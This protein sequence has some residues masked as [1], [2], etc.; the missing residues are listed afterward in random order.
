MYSLYGSD[1]IFRNLYILSEPFLAGKKVRR[2]SD[3]R[4]PYRDFLKF[5]YPAMPVND[6]E[7]LFI[8]DAEI[9]RK[10]AA[11]YSGSTLN[12][13]HQDDIIGDSY[14]DTE[15]NRRVYQSQEALVEL[16]QRDEV[17]AQIFDLVIHSIFITH[18]RTTS[19]GHQSHGGSA[20]GAIGAVW[21][22]MKKEVTKDDLKELFIHEITH[23][24]LFIDELVY[25]HFDYKKILY[26]ENFAYS[27]ILNMMRPLDKVV[28]SMMVATEILLGRERH[29]SNK[30]N[31]TVHPS[32]EH[33]I[34]NVARSYHTIMNLPNLEDLLTL[35]SLE[36][37]ESSFQACQDI[38]LGNPK[39][40]SLLVKGVDH[41]DFRSTS[42][43]S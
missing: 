37:V 24:L 7:D 41:V 32:D 18:T 3:L 20:S 16:Y 12:D 8:N 2:V 42:K 38:A 1:A 6:N 15:K 10:L 5:W 14:S 23:H 39:T 11:A 22:S 36:L 33:M 26:K 19:L 34:E 9:E 4:Q 35:R 29:F 31:V 13:L 25:G 17:F 43:I 30:D 27:S 28:H 21:L 40:N